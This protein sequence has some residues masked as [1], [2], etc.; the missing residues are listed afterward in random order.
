MVQPAFRH[1]DR[2]GNLVL[3]ERQDIPSVQEQVHK[4]VQPVQVQLQEEEIK[5]K[6]G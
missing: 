3:H 1:R 4:E 6:V 5:E 2:E